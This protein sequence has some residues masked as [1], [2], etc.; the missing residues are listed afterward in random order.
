MKVGVFGGTFDPPH[1]GHLEIAGRAKA[2]LHLERILFV[3]AWIPPHK[4]RPDLTD[5][6]TRVRMTEAAVEGHRDFEV[7]RIEAERGGASYTV[8]T[9]TILL[10]RHP[11]WSMWLILGSDTLLEMPG[12]KEPGRIVCMAR[13]GVYPRAGSV[14]SEPAWAHGR[15][16]WIE[17]P[18]VEVSSS[19]IRALV[20]D[21]QPI[22]GLVPDPV[23][24]IIEEKG[25]YRGAPR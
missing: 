24:Q 4:R 16:D 10:E 21:G 3:P 12:W 25:L 11:N 22:K 13:L 19:M 6:E 15:V 18:L 9:L 7:S 17:G 20:A 14:R 5:F 2:A 23:V 1:V 8:D